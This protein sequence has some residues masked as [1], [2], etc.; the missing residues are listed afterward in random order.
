[1]DSGGTLSS[2]S[3]QAGEVFVRLFGL[4]NRAFELLSFSTLLLFGLFLYPLGRDRAP[5]GPPERRSAAGLL[6]TLA[7][8]VDMVSEER[9]RT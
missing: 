5:Q 8:K 6:K 7:D 3:L 9:R 2:P 1:M 4:E